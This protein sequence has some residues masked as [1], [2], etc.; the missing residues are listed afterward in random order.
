M[1]TDFDKFDNLESLVRNSI[2]LSIII[3]MMI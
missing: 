2:F 3:L 1:I